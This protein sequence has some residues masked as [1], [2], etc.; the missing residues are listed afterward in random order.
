MAFS[1]KFKHR[2]VLGSSAARRSKEEGLTK[3]SPALQ[4]K[5]EVGWIW[6]CWT[7]ALR[8]N[9]SLMIQACRLSHHRLHSPTLEGK[10]AIE[11]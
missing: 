9:G 7:G 3:R 4:E 10:G 6:F 8:W 11:P 5:G 2:L 1:K